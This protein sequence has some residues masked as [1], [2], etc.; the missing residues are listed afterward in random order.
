M[1]NIELPSV[2]EP[3]QFEE[4]VYKNLLEQGYYKPESVNKSKENEHKNET[5]T[6]VMPPPNVTGILHMGH[7]LNNSLQDIVVRYKRALGYKTLWVPGTDHA[8][9]A[10]QHVVEKELER[11]GKSRKEMGRDAFLQKTWEVKNRHHD[12]IKKQLE[13]IAVSCDWSRERFTLDEG[14]SKA[15]REC[16]VSLYERGLVYKGQ[17]L[18]NYC[19]HCGTALS[20]DE[21][22]YKE[23]KSFLW[24]IKY[25]FSD[26]SGYVVVA[27]TRP[28]TMFADM[29]VAV[30]PKDERYK[31]LVGKTIALP[32]TNRLIPIIEDSFVDLEFGSGAVKITPSHDP[33]DYECAKRHHLGFMNLLDSDG[34][35]NENAP[36]EYRGLSVLD[37]RKKVVERLKEDGLLLSE[38]PL[39]HEVGHCYR[40]GTI[41]EPYLSEQWFV[42]MKG[43]A[44]KALNALK[45]K[46]IVFYPKKWESTYI[47]WMKN[48][49]PWCISRQLWWGH[50]IPAWTCSDCGN[51][52]VSREDP[53]VCPHCGSTHLKQDEDVL[54]TW[55]SSWLWPFST[56]G[57]PEKTKDLKTYFPTNTLITAYDIIFFWVSRMIMASLE[58][59]GEVPFKDIYITSLVRDKKGRKM[60]K[61]LGNGID[62]IEIVD[63]YGSDAMKFT[64]AFMASQGQDIQID[65]DSF[66]LGSKFCNKVWNASRYLLMNLEGKKL[67]PL[68]NIKLDTWAKWIYSS[69]NDTI[70]EMRKSFDSYKINDATYAIYNFFWNDFC[71]VYIERT[72][73][74]LQ[75][76]SKEKQNETISIL[77]DILSTSLKLMNPIIPLVT[78]EIYSHFPTSKKPLIASLY[79]VYNKKMKYSEDVKKVNML[80]K[81]VKSIRSLKNTLGIQ[82]SE[83]VSAILY[84]HDEK[85]FSFIQKEAD[86]IVSFANLSSIMFSSDVKVKGNI[87]MGGVG[88][89][90]SITAPKE[91]NVN[92]RLLKLK[93]EKE[94]NEKLMEASLK[95]LQ[96][97]DFVK[98]ASKE[99]VEKEEEKLSEFKEECEKINT[100]I[101]LLEALV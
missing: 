42:D 96:N 19:P 101:S 16:F 97:E 38:K 67:I 63:M 24:D 3:S 20:D 92:D 40:C 46:E 85:V 100:S 15:V 53:T 39:S 89:E 94:K 84:V 80:L 23:E 12:I 25:P 79:P 1:K 21:V 58:F 26:G 47:H 66:K 90:C 22:E 78:E 29:A 17:Y 99:A 32:Y 69:L 43:M 44:K 71:S 86:S 98:R 33:N 49:K 50:R 70:K 18:V 82:E 10:T 51:V 95:K 37:A 45:K 76:R 54:D 48:I 72:K 64:L 2:Y 52:I 62:P 87:F 60:S 68:E 9:I 27:T 5:F 65:K 35:L 59:M 31:N 91:I 7:A 75:S 4:R 61:S 93:K 30:N 6:V 14:L 13:T 41:I 57:W 11:E 77:I 56:L 81:I 36:E 34:N 83:K 8:G 28:E 55:F 74:Y 88:Y 73:L